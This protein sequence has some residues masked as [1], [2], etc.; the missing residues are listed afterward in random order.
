[1]NSKTLR[2]AL[3]AS[4][5]L[6]FITLGSAPA[7]GAEYFLQAQ[8]T[9]AT[10]PGGATVPMWAYARCTDATFATCDAATVP[11]PA[12]VV[13]P[14]EGLTVNLRNTLPA[15]VSIVIPG[16]VTT[17]T[18]VWS[19]GSSGPRPAVP[20]GSPPARV[21]SF[22][23]ETATGATQV[24]SWPSLKAG[25]Y[26][27]H[28]GT[29]PQVQVQMGLYGAVTKDHAA[30]FAYPGVPYTNQATL[31]YSE[32][33]PALHEA[34]G[35]ATPTYGTPSGPTSTLEYVPKY[36]LVNGK[37]YSA[38]DPA[39][40][41]VNVGTTT[42]LR[43]INAGLNT[44][45]PVVDG[46]YMRMIAED[47]NPYPWGGNPRQRYSVFLPAAKTM[48]ATIVAQPGTTRI[49]IYD[50]ALALTNN[51]AGDGGMF[52]FINVTDIGSSPVITSSPVLTGTRGTPYSYQVVATDADGDVLTYSLT[53][54]PAGMTINASTGLVSWTPATNQG[55]ANPV[56]LRATDPTARFATQSFS[57]AVASGAGAAPV[58]TSTPVTTATY[59]VP[60]TYQ[61]TATDA[62]SDPLTYSLGPATVAGVTINPATGLVSWTPT[63]AQI[64]PP[65][66]TIVVR[67]TDGKTPF[68]TQ[69]YAVTVANANYAPTAVN[70]SYNMVQGGTLTVNAASGVLANDSDP[71]NNTLTALLVPA[72]GPAGGG[73][74]MNANGLGGFTYTPPA[75]LPT[76]GSSATRSFSYQAQDHSGG[77]A[78][79]VLHTSNAATVT[80]TIAANRPPTTVN[81]TFAAPA[82]TAAP[83]TAQVLSVLA[84]DSDPDT[85]IDPTNTISTAA[86]SLRVP[87]NGQ[88]NKGGTVTVNPALDGTFLYTPA[89]GFR[90]TETFTYR[91]LDTRG[92]LSSAATVRVNVQ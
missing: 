75:N 61:V 29:H 26:L 53:T 68:V 78:S 87:N 23:H 64:S 72:S 45:V 67:V 77:A 63:L 76:S 5:V 44:H 19:D 27:Y 49:A 28:S 37:A 15:S 30:G 55:G 51:M 79:P 12:L 17:M 2:A 24:Y 56:A 35:G 90:G 38:G 13:P 84:N 22:T 4:A 1:M 65:N 88:P 11:G 73:L 14:G 31:V 62:D 39:V 47:G 25:T 16:Q 89:Q 41:T 10:M 40:A 42:L 82:R 8:A 9:T 58:I 48:D 71:E 52:A 70:D 69:S 43:F 3:A 74:T 20:A 46:P 80:I 83:Y 59:G 66:R 85:A 6:G 36:F 91:V 50:R 92:A 7:L 18:P 81:D 34:V 32:I 33:D 57:I 54:A 60:Y 86:G 21:R